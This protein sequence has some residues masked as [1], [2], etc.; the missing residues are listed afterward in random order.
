VS[1]VSRARGDTEASLLRSHW[2]FTELGRSWSRE[3][4]RSPRARKGR[5]KGAAK[6]AGKQEVAAGAPGAPT[7]DILSR[8]AIKLEVK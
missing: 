7:S 5:A 1:G 8:T 2:Q 6:S 4:R 3:P